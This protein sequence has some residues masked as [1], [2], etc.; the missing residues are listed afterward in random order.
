MRRFRTKSR[1]GDPGSGK[2]HMFIGRV[3]LSIKRGKGFVVLL[4]T[5]GQMDWRIASP[6]KQPLLAGLGI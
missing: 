5:L 2:K 6:V 1:I 3:H 4:R